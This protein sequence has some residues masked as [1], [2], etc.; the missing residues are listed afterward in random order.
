MSDLSSKIQAELNL[1]LE[2]SSKNII[3]SDKALSEEQAGLKIYES[4]EVRVADAND[5]LFFELKKPGIIGPHYMAPHEWLESARS[6]I[7]FMLY[8]SEDIRSSNR[9]DNEWPSNEWMH[10][11][12]E[13]HE[14]LM[15][16]AAHI[17]SFLRINGMEAIS[18]QL[19]D[20]IGQRYHFDKQDEALPKYATRWPERHAAYI[21]GLGT[22][23]LSKGLITDN[24]M[25]GR[26]CSVITDAIMEPDKRPY[27]EIYEYC[28]NCG[29]CV[30]RC[31]VGAISME[32]GK[33]HERCGAFLDVVLNKCGPPYYGCGKCQ[34][35]VPC[36]CRIP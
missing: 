1:F 23:G 7:C 29:A 24:G 34:V 35:G 9:K 15:S 31:P 6:V 3:P 27:N 4:A 21:A 10:G 17:E 32:S 22:F 2:S 33:D 19:D 16:A 20:R 25:A 13:G 8:Y 28:S 14:M 36:E 11:R 26:L 18:P 30:K 12:I 5:L